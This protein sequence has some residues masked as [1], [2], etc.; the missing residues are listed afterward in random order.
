M[1]TTE[2]LLKAVDAVDEM[3]K[4]FNSMPTGLPENI[5]IALGALNEARCLIAELSAK[6]RER[7]WRPIESAKTDGTWYELLFEG[8]DDIPN[9]FENGW[10]IYHG[11]HSCRAWRTK[12][13]VT[14]NPK[15]YRP[16]V[17][18]TPPKKE[19]L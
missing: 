4:E 5:K 11:Y 14:G 13:H 16:L 17:L 1:R 12:D 2:E 6:L 18:P 19:S 10:Q 9:H 7:E 3:Y 15:Y 8:D